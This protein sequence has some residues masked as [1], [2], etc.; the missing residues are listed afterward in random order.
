MIVCCSKVCKS[1]FQINLISREMICGFCQFVNTVLCRYYQV[2]ISY[3][4][5]SANAKYLLLCLVDCSP[6]ICV[7]TSILLWSKSIMVI[8]MFVSVPLPQ[9]T[10]EGFLQQIS[11][12]LFKKSLM[13]LYLSAF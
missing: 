5:Q 1:K 3:D 6:N 2:F 13:I 9:I 10:V 11:I 12:G 7:F 4:Y 8:S